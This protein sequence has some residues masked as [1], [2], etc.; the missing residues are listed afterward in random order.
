M[1]G[2]A[3]MTTINQ[4]ERLALLAERLAAV[5]CPQDCA[6]LLAQLERCYRLLPFRRGAQ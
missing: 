3:L 2:G 6:L 1:M 5:L 4:H